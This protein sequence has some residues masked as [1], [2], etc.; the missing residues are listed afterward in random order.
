[1][2]PNYGKTTYKI[3]LRGDGQIE[4]KE[5]DLRKKSIKIIEKYERYGVRR[6]RFSF[7]RNFIKT[8]KL[9]ANLQND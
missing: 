8:K 9:N 4:T 5:R 7:E 2:I 1:M 6:I 3:R